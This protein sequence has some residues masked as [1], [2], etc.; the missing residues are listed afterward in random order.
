MPSRRN[1]EL[2]QSL[3]RIS[4]VAGVRAGERRLVHP[5][6]RGTQAGAVCIRLRKPLPTGAMTA[7][8]I[9]VAQISILPRKL[10]QR[11]GYGFIAWAEIYSL[12]TWRRLMVSIRARRQ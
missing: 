12:Q 8:I 7:S 3:S 10:V 6:L 2:P 9:P 5:G 4:P 1:E 11:E